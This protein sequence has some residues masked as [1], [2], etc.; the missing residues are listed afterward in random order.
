MTVALT[1]TKVELALSRSFEAV[2]AK[3]PGG[4]AVAEAR[5]AA[6]G[7]FAALGLPHRRV[8]QWK[9]TD[10]RSALKE[11]LAPAVGDG[12]RASAADIDAALEELSGARRP[13]RRVRRWR[14]RA[15]AFD[16]DRG[17]GA[18]DRVARGSTEVRR[19][20]RRWPVPRKRRRPGGRDRAQHRVHDGRRRGPPG[21]GNQARQAAAAGV[22]PRRQGRAPR[23]HAQR[24]RDRRRRAC[25]RDRG[26][27]GARRCGPG[28]GQYAERRCSRR[29]RASRPRQSHAGRRD[30][31]PPGHLAGDTRAG[32]D[33]TTLSS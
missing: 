16:A 27:R 24:H 22:R 28:P 15:R 8:E 14:V 33:A 21:R 23:H 5:K 29:R 20:H 6:I 10:L 9:W 17:C 30:R 18:G 31:E 19:P 3:L 4:R 12:A 2:A 25:D 7:A 32:R 13:S 11:P 26:P 1:R